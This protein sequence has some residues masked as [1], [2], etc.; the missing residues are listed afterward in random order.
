MSKFVD[1]CRKEWD[2]LGVPEAVSNE[3]A[4]DLAVDLAEAEAEGASPEEVLGNGAFDARSFAASWAT[5][6]G[7]VRH[8]RRAREGTRWWRWSV[9]VSAVVSL[10]AGAAGLVILGH[11]REASVAATVFHRSIHA[12]FPG[13]RAIM[14][15]PHL[16]SRL[17][18][19][20]GG[21]FEPL[22]LILLV[23]GLVGLCLALWFWR[24]WS[25][26]RRRPGFDEDVGLPSYL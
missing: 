25:T 9:I 20:E 10:V 12:P 1:E 22:G 21:A 15:G 13:P 6:R 3:M 26:L 2:R 4:A 24:P 7:M 5:A 8:D 17:I 19:L 16:P 11:R 14:I 23:V 18:F